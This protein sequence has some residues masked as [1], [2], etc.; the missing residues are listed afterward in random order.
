MSFPSV[1]IDNVLTTLAHYGL[2]LL[3]GILILIVGWVVANWVEEAVLKRGLKV[4]RFDE[5][6]VR[7]FAQVAKVLILGFVAIIV[8]RILG[9]QTASFIAVIGGLSV[10]I[11]LAWQGVL[12]DFAAGIMILTIRPFKVGDAVEIGGNWVAIDKIGIVV[13]SV[14]TFDNLAMTMPNSK[15]WGNF[16]TNAS[17]NST[18]RLTMEVRL[19]YDDDIDKAMQVVADVLENEELVLSEPKPLV[20]ILRLDENSVIM[21]A[22]PWAKTSDFWTMNYNVQ[23]RIKERFDEEGLKMPYPQRDVHFLQKN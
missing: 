8:L 21:R 13:T 23:K 19:S 4:E 1:N 12:K 15:I 11:G 5:T 2:H 10:G 20:A 18:R 3:Y 16:I 6:I 7:I 22:R 14:H 17:Q 9:I